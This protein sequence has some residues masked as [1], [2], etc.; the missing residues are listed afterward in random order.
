[1]SQQAFTEGHNYLCY[2][3]YLLGRMCPTK[4]ERVKALENQ[5]AKAEEI[6]GENA[7]QKKNI[8]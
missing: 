3:I 7:L 8:F 4:L 1:M 2:D 6:K 5:K